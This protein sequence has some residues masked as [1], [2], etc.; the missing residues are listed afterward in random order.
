MFDKD[1][2]EKP[3]WLSSEVDVAE[4]LH[5]VFCDKDHHAGECGWYRSE[6]DPSHE[7][8]LQAAKLMLEQVSDDAL[9]HMFALLREVKLVIRPF[10]QDYFVD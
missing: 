9:W 7:R 8:F 10:L 3:E 1:P 2:L 4:E 6:D 5:A